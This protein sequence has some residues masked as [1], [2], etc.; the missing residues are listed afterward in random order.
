MIKKLKLLIVTETGE[1]DGFRDLWL[2]VSK[3][4]GF[5]IGDVI[6]NVE[7]VNIL[8]YSEFL[9]IVQEK[10]ITDYLFDRFC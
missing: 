7:T 6:D 1:V 3:I 9:T 8:Y 4:N 10:K 5:F 2:D